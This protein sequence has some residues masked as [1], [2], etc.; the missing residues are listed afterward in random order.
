MKKLLAIGS[1]IVIL[2]AAII[3]LTNVS[4]KE[5]LA[6]NPYGTNDLKQA[7]IDQLDDPNYQNIILPDALKEKIASGEPVTAYLFSPTC[8]H[9]ANMTPKLMPIAKE[10]GVQIDQLNVLEFE[11][12]W[13][14]YKIE[15]RGGTPTMIHFRDGK[16]VDYR[17][18]DLPEDEIKNFFNDVVLK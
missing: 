4:N 3:L 8:G 18:G 9:C 6:N 7:T 11:E 15:E 12:A 1:V 10:M 17:V 14:E 2:F 16:E 5:K 13:D